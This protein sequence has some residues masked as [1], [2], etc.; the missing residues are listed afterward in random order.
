VPRRTLVTHELSGQQAASLSIQDEK[1]NHRKHKS[2]IVN[3]IFTDL[4]LH[5]M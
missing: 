5:A 4:T 2:I 3:I 1:I